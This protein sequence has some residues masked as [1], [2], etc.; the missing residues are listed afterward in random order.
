MSVCTM[1]G[2]MEGVFLFFCLHQRDQHLTPYPQ[3]AAQDLPSL[4]QRGSSAPLDRGSSLA[5][6]HLVQASLLP[7]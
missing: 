7:P 6:P 1:V 2:T 3:G 4:Q 5:H